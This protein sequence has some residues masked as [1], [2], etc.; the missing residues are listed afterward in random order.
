VEL[1]DQHETRKTVTVLFCDLVGSTSLGE[2][3]DPEALR[4]LLMRYYDEMRAIVERHGGLVEKFIGDAV[5]AVFG[6]PATHED[7]ALRAV[8]AA[9]EMRG[10]LGELSV[11]L[12]PG[13]GLALAA[14]TGINTG[15]VVAGDSARGHALVTGDVVN[16]AARLEQAAA[17][18][19]ILIGDT[20]RRLVENA[21]E[22]EEVGVLEL[23]GKNV[24]V[25]AWRVL[26]VREGELP[27]ARR[28]DAPLVGRAGELAQLRDAFER[29]VHERTPYLFTVLGVPGIGKTRLA[30][31]LVAS[32]AGDALVLTGRCLSYGEGIT[33]QPLREVVR[34]ATGSDSPEAVLALLAKEPDSE[35]V[36]EMLGAAL[37]TGGEEVAAGEIAWATRRLLES[38]ASRH[39]VL[40]VFED[41]HWAE[42]TF[43]DLV[44]YVAD[45]A[46]DAPLLLLCSARPDLLDARPGWAGGKANA[47]T[48]RLEALPPGEA[49]ELL[50]SLAAEADIPESARLRVADAAE[51]NPLFLEQLVAMLAEEPLATDELRV[52]PTIDALL[53]ERL[54]R[55]AGEERAVLE[56]AAVL[57]REFRIDTLSPLLPEASVI[58]AP[59]VLE[60]LVRKQF[61]RLQRAAEGDTF[62]FRHVLIQ[63]A[64]YRSLPKE[65]RAGLHERVASALDVAGG[66]EVD[67]LVGYHLEQA[68]SARSSLGFADEQTLAVGRRAGELLA[69]SGRRAFARGDVPAVVN[70]FGRAARLL[71]PDDPNRLELLP[72]LAQALHETG[73][74]DEPTR[75]LDDALERSRASGL[76]LVEW[77]ATIVREIVRLGLL[78]HD[79][80]L[81]VAERTAT[82]ALAAFERLADESGQRRAWRVLSDV[83]NLQ[84]S[85]VGA[86]RASEQAALLRRGGN[87]VEDA[88]IDV[89][90]GW[91]KIHGPDP[92]SEV[93]AWCERYLATADDWPGST[94]LMLAALAWTEAMLG[95]VVDAREHVR[96]GQASLR[97][98]GLRI[99]E[100]MHAVLA[101]YVELTASDPVATAAWF[102]QA[103]QILGESGER[104]FGSMSSLERARAVYDQ[105]SYEEARVLT[106]ALD[107]AAELDPE[108]RGKA[109]GLEA[110][111]AARAGD[112]E[113]ALVFIAN[114]L[115]VVMATDFPLYQSYVLLDQAEVCRLV[116]Q[117]E[118]A[119]SA[120]RHALQ[121]LETKGHRAGAANARALLAE[122]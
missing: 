80:D 8:K 46:A 68:F 50:D 21:V 61:L 47:T 39:P 41:V 117:R 38:L 10:R 13:Y 28:L 58:G 93:H 36:A 18:G 34:D 9:V 31:E 70:L 113:A 74:P 91:S 14:R 120:A 32:L 60:G 65:L 44:E 105:G 23:K 88:W 35:R 29:A 19:E 112:H 1:D 97:E 62:R 7:D 119:V 94:A 95:R 5:M 121:L 98:L 110:K 75:V 64:A 3:M 69:V 115:A 12:E 96:V 81:A 72:D 109:L 42:P 48:I 17:A 40:V 118:D 53:A 84:G 79:Y 11:E 76:E 73:D 37:G 52:P 111:L 16:V 66:G 30:R 33:Y 56:R 82:G 100:G 87:R 67:E 83:Y 63:S 51:G 27:V 104:W 86:L 55:L 45:L 78:P 57:G 77:Q 99:Q 89:Y 43:L 22:L 2:G 101:G 122:L 116:G 26:A 49:G 108:W 103:N 71:P 106:E 85:A 92:V 4:R 59:R 24:P 54:E 20:T 15:E 102:E 107:R 90:V 6:V 114:A 25:A